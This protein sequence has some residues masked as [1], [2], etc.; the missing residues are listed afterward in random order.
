MILKKKSQ[1][2]MR[3]QPQYICIYNMS[4]CY[5]LLMMIGFDVLLW[6]ILSMFSEFIF[7]NYVSLEFETLFK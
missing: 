1:L 2:R 4:K 6:F 3:D 5:F 7:L